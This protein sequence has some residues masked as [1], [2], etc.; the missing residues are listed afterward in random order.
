MKHFVIVGCSRKLLCLTLFQLSDLGI[1]IEGDTLYIAMKFGLA[2]IADYLVA[3]R[4]FFFF[5]NYKVVSFSEKI[6]VCF[7]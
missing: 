3:Q 1:L 7:L 2:G 4:F 5:D 6:L